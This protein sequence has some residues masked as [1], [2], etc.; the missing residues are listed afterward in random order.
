M[1]A[2]YPDLDD[3]SATPIE[4]TSQPDRGAGQPN[5]VTRL[6]NADVSPRASKR[7]L[8][9]IRNIA[10]QLAQIAAGW[11]ASF[12]GPVLLGERP[13]GTYLIDLI[14]NVSKVNGR[15][16]NLGMTTVL[17]KWLQGELGRMGRDRNW[18]SKATV[19]VTYELVPSNTFM[20]SHPGH[21]TS[22]AF[23]ANLSARVSLDAD[24]IRQERRSGD[25]CARSC[26]LA[27]AR[28]R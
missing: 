3:L 8:G 13:T 19:E 1:S 20:D 22:Q 28:P 4:R 24:G 11:E 5:E 17:D 16:A 25:R 21:W 23:V 6:H 12:D 14:R 27:S 10:N 7:T 2:S 9:T 26:R 18:L 15:E